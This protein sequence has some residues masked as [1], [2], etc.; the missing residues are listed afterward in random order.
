[1]VDPERLRRVL[2]GVSDDIA[3]LRRYQAARRD[4][5]LADGERVGDLLR[6]FQT[7]LE[8]CID[9]AHHV[10]ASEGWGPPDSNAHAM[11]VLGMHGVHDAELAEGMSDH[12]RFRNVLV[13]LYADVDEALAIDR[14]GRLDELERYV[15]A[16]ASLI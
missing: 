2:Q 12:A 14:L 6:R 16:V 13:H 5:V 7:A 15:A 8:G 11:L 3:R 1:M 10:S 4:E 9:A